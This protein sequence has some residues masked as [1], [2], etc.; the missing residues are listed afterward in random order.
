MS[1]PAVQ[2]VTSGPS[3]HVQIMDHGQFAAHFQDSVDG[4]HIAVVRDADQTHG[5]PV[6]ATL[7]TAELCTYIVDHGRIRRVYQRTALKLRQQVWAYCA[8]FVE[9]GQG[10]GWKKRVTALAATVSNGKPL[11]E[12]SDELAIRVVCLPILAAV[13][14]VEASQ[15][16]EEKEMVAAVKDLPIAAWV[17]DVRG[18][19]HLGLANILAETGDLSGYSTEAKVWKRL[20][21]AVLDGR[22]QG[23]PGPGATDEDWIEH[24]Y[25]AERRSVMWN[26]GA[27]FVKCGGHYR[28]LYDRYK[29]E[30]LARPWCGE[31]R[32]KTD[33]GP[34]DHCTP[35]HAHN[36]AARKMTKTFIR[37]LHR[38][39][40]RLA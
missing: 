21:L 25:R 6:D 40:R 27:N 16:H 11:P 28:E 4:G 12:G 5:A 33:K 29:A 9:R 30:Y 24:G 35:G 17:A 2:P 7:T 10:D 15:K 39:W 1:A 3:G 20:G 37:D 8:R 13:D 18:L 38:A 31:C 36:R 34:R 26:I 14:L 19:G 32:A 22:R 23:A